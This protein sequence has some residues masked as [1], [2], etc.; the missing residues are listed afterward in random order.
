MYRVSKP[1]LRLRD[2]RLLQDP[3]L[4]SAFKNS[5]STRRPTPLLMLRW[6][7]VSIQL[8]TLAKIHVLAAI[9]W[10]RFRALALTTGCR[11]ARGTHR[12]NNCVWIAVLKK[13]QHSGRI[14]LAQMK[15]RL[16]N[17]LAPM[18]SLLPPADRLLH[19]PLFLLTYLYPIWKEMSFNPL[20]AHLRSATL[21]LSSC[22]PVHRILPQGN[23]TLILVSG[24]AQEGYSISMMRIRDTLF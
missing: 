20:L 14:Y 21:A 4:I 2:Y 23:P 8:W 24:S 17:S 1:L 13:A 12:C 18:C 11:V 16:S 15:N 19:S 3:G 6:S 9:N 22:Y 7:A 10:Q 5:H